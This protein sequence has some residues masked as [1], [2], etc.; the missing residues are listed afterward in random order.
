MTEDWRRCIAGVPGCFGTYF[1]SF[2][3]FLFRLKVMDRC[4]EILTERVDPSMP[5]KNA[6]VFGKLNEGE[7]KNN[8]KEK[9]KIPE[10]KSTS[11]RMCLR[12][13]W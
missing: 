13:V 4:S 5:S 9:E 8:L 11:D 2:S 7:N 3:P 12:A 10:N 6:Y 1:A